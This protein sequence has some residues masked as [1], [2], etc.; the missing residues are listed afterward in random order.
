VVG[1]HKPEEG[2]WARVPAAIVGGMITVGITRGV[3]DWLR[4]SQVL[5]RYG[6]AALAFI[7]GAV[8]A[9]YIAF[10][11]RK[12]GEFLIET[13]NE[14]RKVV[15]PSQDEVSNS[16]T[17]VIATTVLLGGLVFLMDVVFGWVSTQVGLY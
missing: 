9:L 14:L 4:D 3:L 1:P 7:L 10:F 11:H 12:I 8:V 16:T 5:G 13:E 15:W 2:Q 17:V 6:S